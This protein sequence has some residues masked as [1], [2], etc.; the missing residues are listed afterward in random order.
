MSLSGLS[1][2]D[3]RQYSFVGRTELPNGTKKSKSHYTIGEQSSK[4]TEEEQFI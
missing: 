3:Q 4:K 2:S 1:Y